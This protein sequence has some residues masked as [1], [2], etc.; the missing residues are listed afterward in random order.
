MT[1]ISTL[2]LTAIVM[3]CAPSQD[4]P[5]DTGSPSASPQAVPQL[6]ADSPADPAAA[7]P[8]PAERIW[9]EEGLEAQPRLD[10]YRARIPPDLGWTPGTTEWRPVARQ[11]ADSIAA[12]APATS[13]A[14]LMA[15]VQLALEPSG[16]LGR[17]VWEVTTRVL[18][19]DD[20]T[21]TGVILR[22]GYQDDALAGHDVR[23][24]MRQVADSW[25]VEAVLE[26]YQC[27]RGVSD[28][29]LCL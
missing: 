3:A 13:I 15:E 12:I 5:A 25:V 24:E 22:W 19:R 27:R 28:S 9:S 10:A 2:L 4:P 20:G 17:E 29:G 11:L 6:P 26:R 1:R 14:A 8:T 23:V 7:A 16:A 18:Q 21:A